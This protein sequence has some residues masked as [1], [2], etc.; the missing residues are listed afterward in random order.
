M[1]N[2]PASVVPKIVAAVACFMI[3]LALFNGVSD[4]AGIAPAWSLAIAAAAGGTGAAAA[5]TLDEAQALAAAAKH[6]AL[7][8]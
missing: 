5:G 8:L 3:T 7:V 6:G 2:F 4:L 1:S